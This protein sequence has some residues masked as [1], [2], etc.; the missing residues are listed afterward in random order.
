MVGLVE[1]SSLKLHL[2]SRIHQSQKIVTSRGI[3]FPNYHLWGPRWRA[4]DGMCFLQALL[5]HSPRLE[6]TASCF[7]PVTSGSFYLQRFLLSREKF[8]ILDR[9]LPLHSWR[10][11]C[12][13]CAPPFHPRA[14]WT[15]RAGG[16]GSVGGERLLRLPP[17]DLLKSPYL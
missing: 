17:P 16:L 3:S 2:P 11:F 5:L 1:N 14:L 15:C 7:L 9:T 6:G 4:R 12:R 13:H 10:Q 8:I